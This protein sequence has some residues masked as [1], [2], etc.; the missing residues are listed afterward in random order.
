MIPKYKHMNSEVM[1]Y[2][3]SK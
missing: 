3:W 2:I 1:T